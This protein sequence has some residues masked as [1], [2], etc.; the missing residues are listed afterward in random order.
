MEILS[1]GAQRS[2][3][4]RISDDVWSGGPRFAPA[5]SLTLPG[6]GGEARRGGTGRNRR[7]RPVPH[8]R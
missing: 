7:A 6:R 4:R 8:G 3:H 2:S 1:R 5:V